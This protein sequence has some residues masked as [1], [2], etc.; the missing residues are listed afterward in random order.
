VRV[1]RGQVA[2]LALLARNDGGRGKR[3]AETSALVYCSACVNPAS[4][5]MKYLFGDTDIAARR[6]KVVAEVFA[7]PT[8]AFLLDAV[9]D[10]LRLVVDLGCGPGYTTHLLAEVLEC[11]HVAGLDSSE[12]FVSLAQKTDKV[13][14][15]VHDI[16]SVPFPVGPSDIMY[17]R[18]LLTHLRKPH[19]VVARWATQLRP[20][21]LLLMQET[22]WIETDNDVFAT[23]LSIVE[24]VLADQST[25]LYAGRVLDRMEECGG[26][27]KRVSRVR[28]FR[29]ANRDAARMFFM[30]M[31]SWKDSAYVRE[32]YPAR[33]LEELQEN[34]QDL[35]TVPDSVT[36]IEWG[37]R[38]IVWERSGRR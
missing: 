12:H 5:V 2:A 11:D 25:D 23:Y 27:K 24:A 16:T 15:H 38:E 26:L 36:E 17:C 13:S 7:E 32:N 10:R 18:F 29:V 33:M 31:Q 34:L 22:E 30:N 20:R 37:L 1:R 3:C 21:G 4:Y 19:E 28:R 14:F 6:L 8:R 35:A 9:S